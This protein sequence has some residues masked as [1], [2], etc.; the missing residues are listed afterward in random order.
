ML[1]I[2]RIERYSLPA[3]QVALDIVVVPVHSAHD[4]EGEIDFAE[5]AVLPKGIITPD[6]EGLQRDAPKLLSIDKFS[7]PERG[8]TRTRHQQSNL[9][10]ATKL[11]ASKSA[12]PA[13]SCSVRT[14]NIGAIGPLRRH[15]RNVA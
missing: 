5:Q 15:A 4:M 14:S 3:T 1:L 7:W 12:C 11:G 9:P 13:G 8:E 2:A 10:A 6:E